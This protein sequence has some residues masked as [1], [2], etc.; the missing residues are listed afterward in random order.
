MYLNDAHKRSAESIVRKVAQGHKLFGAGS[1][2]LGFFW[3]ADPVHKLAQLDTVCR[4]LSSSQR[5]G[6]DYEAYVLHNDIDAYLPLENEERDL[7]SKEG[8]PIKNNIPQ[9]FAL[10]IRFLNLHGQNKDD[11]IK[12]SVQDLIQHE[13][14]HDPVSTSPPSFPADGWDFSSSSRDLTKP[15]HFIVEH[16]YVIGHPES[17]FNVVMS[18]ADHRGNY[19]FREMVTDK[20]GVIYARKGDRIIDDGRLS[21]S[22]PMAYRAKGIQN[23]A[24]SSNGDSDPNQALHPFT[25]TSSSGD[26]DSDLPVPQQPPSLY[27]ILITLSLSFSVATRQE[28][29]GGKSEYAEKRQ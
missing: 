17:I 6:K 1:S 21:L 7:I 12:K 11:S 25:F 9:N 14:S 22:V 29:G 2:E 23:A 28:A 16:E 4:N 24:L 8:D 26:S 18:S 10:R 19:V 13:E 15:I 20:N 27:S 3:D 5:L